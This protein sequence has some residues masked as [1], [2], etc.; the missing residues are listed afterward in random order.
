MSVLDVERLAPEPTRA[1]W[2]PA[3]RERVLA[4]GVPL[5][6]LVSWAVLVHVGWIDA[7]FFPAPS[8]ITWALVQ[9]SGS[10]ELLTNVTASLFRI[11]AGFLVG[12]APAIVLGLLMGLIPAVRA[13]LGQVVAA[14]YPIPKSALLPLILL[15][16][17]LGESSKVVLL[18]A[19]VFFPVLINTMA[20]VL[21]LPQIYR[22]VGTNFGA[23]GWRFY[24]TVAV[25]WALPVIFAGFKIG[26]NVAM[27]LIVIAEITGAKSGIGFMIWNGWLTFDI[28]RMY[29]GLLV[30]AILGVLL[31]L[32][33]QGLE[34]LLVPWR[35]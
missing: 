6:L 24:T 35:S 17:G 32:V 18:A 33:L 28:E 10:G 5:L 7:R 27:V 1:W 14:V 4:V 26:M 15:I 20:G 19:G 30:I 31:S 13:A 3:A 29:V 12:A 34:R 25:P 2:S 9:L 16:F 11:F 23:R 21:T 22:E 8:S